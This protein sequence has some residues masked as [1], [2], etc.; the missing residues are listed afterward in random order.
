VALVA[1]RRRAS[2]SIQLARIRAS[3]NGTEI[4]RG[5]GNPS[6]VTIASTK[7]RFETYSS[8]VRL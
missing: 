3:H 8:S 5:F 2:F 6:E 7:R 4:G 1:P